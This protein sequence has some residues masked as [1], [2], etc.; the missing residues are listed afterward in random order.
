MES[1]RWPEVR[2]AFEEAL[3]HSPES[4]EGLLA[5]EY[6]DDSALRGEVANLLAFHRRTGDLLPAPPARELQAL[7]PGERVGPYRV[8]EPLGHGGMGMVYLAVRA[9]AAYQKRVALKVLKPGLDTAEILR[10]FRT[11]RQI[12]AALDH[13][14]I[15]K[16]LDG[17][18]TAQGLPFF[19]LEHVD[20]QPIDEHCRR[21][22]LT[23]PDRLRL[24]R[25]V[26]AAVHFAHRNLVVHRDLKPGNILVTADG[27]PKLLDFGIAKLLNPELSGRTLEPTAFG[28]HP[29]TPEYASPEQIRGE[30]ITTAS[31][32][33]AL[34]VLLYEL[35]TGH[36]PFRRR[37]SNPEELRRRIIEEDPERPSTVIL[38]PL[39]KHRRRTRRQPGEAGK[40]HRQLDGDLDNIVL[41]ALHKEPERRYTSVEQLAED[42]RRHLEGEPVQARPQTWSYRA[43]KFCRRHRAGLTVAAA[44]LLALLGFSTALGLSAVRLT[45][46]TEEAERERAVAEASKKLLLDSFRAADPTRGASLSA[47]EILDNALRELT[48]ASAS[49][50]AARV[51]IDSLQTIGQAYYGLGLYDR[52]AAV[53]RSAAV[54]SRRVDGGG[55]QQAARSLAGLGVSLHALGQY[56][57]AERWLRRALAVQQDTLGAD[58][59]DVAATANNLALAVQANGDDEAALELY[60]QAL[61]V[62]QQR[63]AP[64]D[65]RILWGLNNLG[66]SLQLLDRF[67]EAEP[68][69]LQALERGRRLPGDNA[70][71]VAQSLE[72]LAVTSRGLGRF[73][74]AERYAERSLQLR[75]RRF[76][77]EHPS[78]AD[79]LRAIALARLESGDLAAA[80]P[81]LRQALDLRR[82]A[83]GTGHP[84]CALLLGDLARLEL[85]RGRAA[86][87][88]PLARQALHLLRPFLLPSDRDLGRAELLHGRCLLALGRY[89]AAEAALR[90]SYAI[91]TAQIRFSG[92]GPLRETLQSLA[93]LEKARRR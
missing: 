9:D 90:R 87:A 76:G 71:E 51:K 80:E 49:P 38:E 31:D 46:E 1:A 6:P 56:A 18:T 47:R 88:E 10:R 59:L 34:G 20:G 16:L 17:G 45:Q 75:Q 82:K 44:L 83:V 32:V 27:T 43:M 23:V 81:R 2:H 8:V 89:P 15:A 55:S 35:L 70:P 14:N 72:N 29:M 48:A 65:R 19:V 77:P 42:I 13:P 91:L 25:T 41:T 5:E 74:E 78:V 11:E 64:D 57:P 28:F 36:H 86:Q 33:Y 54:L 63:L 79:S 26:C 84:T 58:S 40:L 22:R 4:W 50:P 93:V 21:Q 60:R 30:P 24:F 73:A 52:S 66:N 39:A 12:L 7:A 3:E 67:A 92:P 69:H 62:W 53:F 37:L 61:A 85:L 68:L